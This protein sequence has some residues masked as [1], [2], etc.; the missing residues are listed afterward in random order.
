MSK[1]VCALTLA[2]VALGSLQDTGAEVLDQGSGIAQCDTQVF[3]EQDCSTPVFFDFE[4]VRPGDVVVS[5]KAF[6]SHCS[7][8]SYALRFDGDLGKKE[9]RTGFLQPG[10]THRFDI[11]NLVPGYYF[12]HVRARG[13]TG[14]CN[15]GHLDSWGIVWTV[16]Q[17][18]LQGT[19]A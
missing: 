2:L 6:E 12:V 7:A 17:L 19:R 16:E 15:E 9:F 18:S 14:G 4:L 3:P 11:E 5:A 10:E 1:I 8:V 13:R